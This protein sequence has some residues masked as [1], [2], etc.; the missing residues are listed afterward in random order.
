M[1]MQ[2]GLSKVTRLEDGWAVEEERVCCGSLLAE[3]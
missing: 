2:Q 1:E 3:A